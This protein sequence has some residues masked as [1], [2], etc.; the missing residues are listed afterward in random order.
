MMT[1]RKPHKWSE[2]I[3]A[4]ADGKPIQYRQI[5]LG[6]WLD[7]EM[8]SPDFSNMGFEWRIKPENIV[9]TKYITVEQ[10]QISLFFTHFKSPNIRFEF[11]PDTGKL[12]KAEV[13][14]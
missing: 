4:W 12:I 2:V 11:D 8:P 5:G 14:G 9:I 10:G 1:E 6:T 3:K 13:L 7:V